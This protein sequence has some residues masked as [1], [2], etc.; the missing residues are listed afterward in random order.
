MQGRPGGS[1]SL[2]RNR[3]QSR[4][5]GGTRNSGRGDRRRRRRNG[6]CRERRVVFWSHFRGREVEE[7]DSPSDSPARNLNRSHRRGNSLHVSHSPAILA[8][9]IRTGVVMF[10]SSSLFALLPS[11][12]KSVNQSAIGY[13]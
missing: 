6:F 5:S 3:I 8:V 12:A 13:G 9:L 2:E 4:Q 10:F 1:I 7:T 11:V